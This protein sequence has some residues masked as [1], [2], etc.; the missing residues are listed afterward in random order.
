MAHTTFLCAHLS[1]TFKHLLR[2]M[3]RSMCCLQQPATYKCA[4]WAAKTVLIPCIYLF[5]LITVYDHA[6]FDSGFPVLWTKDFFLRYDNFGMHSI[7]AVQ[8]N[9]G[10]NAKKLFRNN[11]EQL[12]R[13]L[14]YTQDKKIPL[15]TN[16]TKSSQH[17]K[18]S[19]LWTVDGSADSTLMVLYPCF[20]HHFACHFAIDK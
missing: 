2:S 12:P 18:C 16:C 7:W 1:D 15:C 9:I 20:T 3:L 19:S 14:T 13:L 4:G 8:I 17:L 5:I 10:C 11:W 6:W